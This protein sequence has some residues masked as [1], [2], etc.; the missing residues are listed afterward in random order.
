MNDAEVI[1]RNEYAI[2]EIEDTELVVID[3]EVISIISEGIQGPTGSPGVGSA[4]I[5]QQPSPE[6]E[7]II[8]HNLGVKP[9]VEVRNAGGAVGI[10]EIIHFS[11][12]QLRIYFTVPTAGEAR[13]I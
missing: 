9:M 7:W 3:R 5:H 2:I 4:F 11:A 12:N 6:V 1:V 10:A 13:C 8:N